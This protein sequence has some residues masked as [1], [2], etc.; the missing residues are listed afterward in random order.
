LNQINDS[1]ANPFE[2]FASL[3]NESNI[4]NISVEPI[5]VKI[6]MISAEDINSY[7]IYLRQRLD[8]NGNIIEKWKSLVERWDMDRNNVESVLNKH[9]IEVS[10]GDRPKLQ[11]QIYA[12]LMTLQKYRNFPFEIYEWIHVIDRYISEIISLINNTI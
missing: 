12:N 11:N 2:S 5:T 3:L 6:P 8:V 9:N 7:E 1:I 10:L 4:I